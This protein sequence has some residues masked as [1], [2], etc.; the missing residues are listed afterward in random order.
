MRHCLLDVTVMP[1]DLPCAR[2]R[3]GAGTSCCGASVIIVSCTR[4]LRRAP[5]PGRREVLRIGRAPGLADPSG[6]R[7]C[8]RAGVA[9]SVS[10]GGRSSL[11]RR[12]WRTR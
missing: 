4:R 5:S 2:P 6:S 3:S 8:I 7:C 11:R 9:C 10:G 12:W 1:C